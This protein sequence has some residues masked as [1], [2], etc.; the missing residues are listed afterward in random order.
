MPAEWS[1]KYLEYT[2]A[3]GVPDR[4]TGARYEVTERDPDGEWTEFGNVT[5]PENH[6]INNVPFDNLQEQ[7]VIGH[8]KGII[9]GQQVAAI[10]VRAAQRLAEKVRPT[11]GV[12]LPPR[13]GEN[14]QG[15]GNPGGGNPG[16]GNPNP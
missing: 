9:G 4:V 16:G 15:G 3:D 13:F 2:V 1:V 10:Q 7:T 8:I 5:F 14:D 12:G 6:P 11:R